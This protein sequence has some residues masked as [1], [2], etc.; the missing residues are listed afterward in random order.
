[1]DEKAN[2]AAVNA[3][4]VL[5]KLRIRMSAVLKGVVS[6]KKA[7]HTFQCQIF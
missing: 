4:D 6:H 1:M 3:K 7:D 2:T 5:R